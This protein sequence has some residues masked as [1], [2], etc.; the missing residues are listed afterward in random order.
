MA[1]PTSCLGSCLRAC[2]SL[3]RCTEPKST[4]TAGSADSNR[5][6]PVVPAL[7]P[8]LQSAVSGLCRSS[9]GPRLLD[10]RWKLL[11]P[12]AQ[13]DIDAG[14]CRPPAGCTGNCLRNVWRCEVSC[15]AQHVFSHCVCWQPLT[16]YE[17][18][19]S[20]WSDCR[21]QQRRH[22][23]TGRASLT[24]RAP[25]GARG[26]RTGGA[27]QRGGHARRR[28]RAVQQRRVDLDRPACSRMKAGSA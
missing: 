8:F 16:V 21:Q 26:C 12:P 5:R 14:D 24:L 20:L 9:P 1:R 11:R 23:E 25:G 15:G 4:P 7:S 19:C 6:G 28:P 18:G 13:L 27:R 22:Q 17:C 10:V 3:D 2:C